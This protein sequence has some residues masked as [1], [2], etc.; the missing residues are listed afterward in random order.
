MND[1]SPVDKTEGVI[2]FVCGAGF[3]SLFC[4]GWG[5]STGWLISIAL[6]CGCLAYKHGDR[7]WYKMSDW[8]GMYR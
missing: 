8:W 4:A 1:G 2:R 5:V 3:G 6:L 7:F